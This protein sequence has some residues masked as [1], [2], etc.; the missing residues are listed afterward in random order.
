M[1]KQET[2]TIGWNNIKTDNMS[3]SAHLGS[4]NFNGLSKEAMN[5]IA[6]LNVPEVM[7]SE[8]SEDNLNSIL[9]RINSN[10]NA[11]DQQ[12]F[13]QLLTKESGVSGEELSA[14]SPFVSSDMYDYFIKKEQK[15]GAKENNDDSST[16]S[17]SDSDLENDDE[18]VEELITTPESEIKPKKKQHMTR[19]QLSTDSSDTENLSYLSS[20]AHTGG[21]FSTEEYTDSEPQQ[22]HKNRKE[23]SESDSVNTSDI[24]YVDDD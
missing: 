14:T 21:E 10:L 18:D 24:N 8:K 6:T 11:N 7:S 22:R 23:L 4:S 12:K 15:G 3:S 2:E 13:E 16:S 5:L 20:S 1:N 17:T 9:G 19:S